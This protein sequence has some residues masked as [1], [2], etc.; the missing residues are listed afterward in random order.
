M[1]IIKK[2]FA[3]VITVTF[4]VCLSATASAQKSKSPP[5]EMPMDKQYEL[6]RKAAPLP[7]GP[8]FYIEPVAGRI[9]QFSILLT[10]N[11]NRSVPG[12]FIRPQIEI[13]EDLLLASKAFALNEE[14]VGT[15][16]K[17]KITRFMDKHEKAFII[18]VQKAGDKTHFFLTIESLFGRLTIDAGVIKRGAKKPG[19]AEAPEPLFY[20]IITR[21][22]EAKSAALTLP[23]GQ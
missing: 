11:N 16:S 7:S 15:A 22:Q 18:D 17:P 1:S 21:V 3:T 14:E 23:Q 19:E 12:T 6:S 8:D 13:L 20:K 4:F 9:L 2:S 10:D 5:V